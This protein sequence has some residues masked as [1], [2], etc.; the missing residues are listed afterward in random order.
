[1]SLDS[2]AGTSM[3]IAH[4]ASFA[5]HACGL[6]EAARDM[7]V[8]DRIAG[9]D[10]LLI[11]VGVTINGV[12]TDGEAGKKD[13]RG[14]SVVETVSSESALYA[15]IIIAH[16][17]IPDPW[18]VGCQAPIVWMLH[19]RPQACFGPEQFGNGNSYSM[20]ANLA[21]W[22]RVKK[23]IT[24]WPYHQMFWSAVIS[25]DKLVVLDAPPI[26]P[27]RFPPE[28]EKHDF[29]NMGSKVNVV[30]ADSWREDVDLFEITNGLIEF[31]KGN[32]GVK[33]HF[34]GMMEP[35]RCWDFLL[36][37]LRTYGALGQV[38]ARWAGM[39]NVFRG[40]DL[41][42]SPHRI[43][44]RVIAEALSCGTPVLAARGCKFATWTCDPA[45]PMDVALALA[46]AIS[47]LNV[48]ST[49]ERVS[50]AASQF[51]LIRYNEAMSAVYKNVTGNGGEHERI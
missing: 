23:M 39:D 10:T 24:F 20:I 49:E 40:A 33:F 43:T 42:V 41:V 19:G 9:H 32:T 4:F 30:V 18:I 45:D 28:G 27:Q 13:V 12:H 35:L 7:I 8:A 5:P 46:G 22:P 38:C 26:D 6:Y 25:A 31:A 14:L 50:S 17:G 29:A 37:E 1:M 47:E 36:S 34:F 16:T 3:N 44:T 2:G 21:K 11:D 51:S 48:D 15:D